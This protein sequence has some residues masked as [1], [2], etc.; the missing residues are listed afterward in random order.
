[1]LTQ[2]LALI[3]WT[4]VMWFWLYATRI[5]AMRR[6]KLDTRTVTRADVLALPKYATRAADNY[7]HLHEQ[8][9]LFYALAFYTQQTGM[10]DTVNERLAWA[11]VGLRVVHSL[12]QA[13]IDFVPLRF[14]LFA[15]ASSVLMAI[16]LRDVI[17]LLC[18]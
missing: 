11:Y 7:N 16:M 9:T 6:A 13:T 10:A 2:V 17:A 18:T 8:P 1:M 15:L 3:A 14:T 12:V 4:L 5:P